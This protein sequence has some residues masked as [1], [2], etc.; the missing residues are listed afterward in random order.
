E[1]VPNAAASPAGVYYIVVYQLGPGQVKT[2]YW[3]VPTTTPANLATVRTTPGT[4][5]AGAPVSRQYVD[6][7]IATKADKT[8]VDQAVANVGA[9]SFLA[10]AGG[11]MTGPITL[12]GTPAAPMQATTKQYVDMGLTS[13]ADVIAGVVPTNELGTGSS[14][15][16]S[17]LLGNGTSAAWGSCPSGGGGTGNISTTPIANQNIAQPSGT[18][19]S[20]NNLANIRYVTAS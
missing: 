4:G 9:G 12:S 17:C 16:G 13:K 18:Q 3:V 5:A 14:T 19:F 8:Y 6:S 7:V 1:L 15:T 20:V 2:E 10:T 11:T